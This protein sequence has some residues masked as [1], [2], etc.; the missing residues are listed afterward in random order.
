MCANIAPGGVAA[1]Y[2]VVAVAGV[3]YTWTVPAGAIGL[4]GQGTAN[5]SFTYPAGYTGG[6]ISVI[7]SNGCGTSGPRTLTVSRLLPATPSAIDVIESQ[8]CPDRIYTYSLI[9]MPSN[10]VSVQWTSP[11]GSTILT[12]QGTP[13][14]TVSYPPTAINGT[15]TATAVNNCGSSTVRSV[16]AKYPTCGDGP[17]PPP[18][19]RPTA[20][21][22][23]TVTTTA[24]ETMQVNVF[25]NPTVSD[26]KLQ[27]VT[28]AKE[29][30][31]VRVLDMQGRELKNLVVSAL[32]TT[33]IGSDLG[34]GAYIMEVKQGN[35]VKTVK[36]I[37][38]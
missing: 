22:A 28:A 29:T 26:F 30:I 8:G 37:K 3:T 36:L 11:A 1:N 16:A 10:A 24:A 7:A 13:S 5:I 34:A 19:P 32:Q 18:G 21:G 35:T 6:T 25:P 2:S 9:G 12:G 20:K 15:V 23:T 4:T 27:V 38:F 17:P 14:I 31:R 33:N